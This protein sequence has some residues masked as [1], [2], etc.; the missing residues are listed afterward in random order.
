MK[1]SYA[2]SKKLPV[3]ENASQSFLDSPERNLRK[4][5]LDRA[6]LD[7]LGSAFVERH[8]Q[9][10]AQRWLFS[11]KPTR[12]P[13]SF[14]QVCQD[15]ELDPWRIR[16]FIR[17]GKQKLDLAKKE[18]TEAPSFDSPEIFQTSLRRRA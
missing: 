4:A 13:I 2:P 1:E 16:T 9:R 18:G 10:L 6:L 14:L 5:I 8:Q 11:N 12:W 15:L 7:Y 17:V 3:A